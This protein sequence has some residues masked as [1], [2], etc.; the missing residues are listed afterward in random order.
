MRS[1]GM[2]Y[3]RAL[4]GMKLS[5]CR[6]LAR[7]LEYCETLV[8]LDLSGNLLDDD[9]LRM[10]ASGLINNLSVVHLDLSHN[11]IADRGVRA[12]AKLLHPNSVIQ[13]V[14]LGDNQVRTLHAIC[15][16]FHQGTRLL[17]NPAGALV[18]EPDLLSRS[19]TSTALRTRI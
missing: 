9:K 3:D 10:L 4:F 16:D 13:I 15:A 12:L 2:D 5:D 7:C 1:V 19:D 8:R 6:S 17:R 11:R 14:E 18:V